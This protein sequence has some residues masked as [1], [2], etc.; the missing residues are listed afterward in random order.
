MDAVAHA[1]ADDPRLAE[2]QKMRKAQA[3]ALA[4]LEEKKQ[5]GGGSWARDE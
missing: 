2:A 3:A 1:S 4:A 5:A